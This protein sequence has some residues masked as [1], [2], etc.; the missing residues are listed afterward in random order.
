MEAGGSAESII[1]A[2]AMQGTPSP[3]SLP[4]TAT[5]VIAHERGWEAGTGGGWK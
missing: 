3:A 5:A 1:L 4:G 2:E